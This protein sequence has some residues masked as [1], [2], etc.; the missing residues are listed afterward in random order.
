[1]PP[2]ESNSKAAGNPASASAP[3][4]GN[5]PPAERTAAL[6]SDTVASPAAL[7]AAGT[8][9]NPGTAEPR[10]DS[11]DV[12]GEAREMLT[13]TLRQIATGAR[14]AA[15]EFIESMAPVLASASADLAHKGQAEGNAR[16]ILEAVRAS[17]LMR[18]AQT[19]IALQTSGENALGVV[20]E[21]AARAL[22]RRVRGA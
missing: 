22:A 14:E 15:A 8:A 9:G 11:P 4:T 16:N 5:P 7:G 3:A 10:Q 19:G 18:A 13:D 12:I 20:L 1:M 21:V 2:I 17:A 6:A